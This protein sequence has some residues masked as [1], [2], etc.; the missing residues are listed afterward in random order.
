MSSGAPDRDDL[1]REL[2]LGEVFGRSFDLARRNY[3]QLLPIFA[4][5]GVIV[6]VVS[7]LIREVTPPLVLP[8]TTNISTLTRTQELAVAASVVRWL[9]YRFANYF[10][11]WLILYFAVAIGCWKLFQIMSQK[12]KLTFELPQRINYLNLA[13]TAL[14]AV[15]IIEV[16]LI[17]VVGPLIFATIL[18]LCFAASAAEGKYVFSAFGR[19][20]S[21]I[22]GKW[23][24]TFLVFTGTQII[25]YLVAYVVSTIVSLLPVSAL[26]SHA[27]MDFVLALEF[28]LVSASMVVLYTSYRRGEEKMVPRPPSLYDNLTSQP[29]GNFS[30]GKKNFC[31]ACGAAVSADEK[32]C[33]NCGAALASQ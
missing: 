16:S 8:T 21:L 31:S 32:F 6:A 10:V 3:L 14:I 12:Q 26:F 5:F 11:D 22:A 33:H 7:T 13:I 30:Y 9:E 1:N 29:M 19:S 23:G 18:Y 17:I 25:V 24:K 15:L 2:T 28:P 4:G 27:V 20:R